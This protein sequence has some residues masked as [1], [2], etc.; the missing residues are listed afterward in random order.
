MDR[1]DGTS[2]GEGER[3]E[4]R[5]LRVAIGACIVLA[6]IEQPPAQQQ[7]QQPYDLLLKGGH[8]IDARNKL[9]AVRDVAIARRQGGGGRRPASTRRRR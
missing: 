6:A 9:S 8:V 4:R 7:R 2:I 5:V 3:D 1:A